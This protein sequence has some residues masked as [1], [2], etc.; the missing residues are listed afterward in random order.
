VLAE[1]EPYRGAVAARQEGVPGPRAADL[2]VIHQGH[3][4]WPGQPQHPPQA[5]DEIL[6][7]P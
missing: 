1:P 4:G 5:T 7:D 6:I 3:G 2:G